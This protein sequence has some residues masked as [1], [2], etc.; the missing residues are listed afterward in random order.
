MGKE[1]HQ[2]QRIDEEI[3]KKKGDS[4]NYVQSGKNTMQLC[5]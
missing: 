2:H 5:R 4:T 3:D 1:E